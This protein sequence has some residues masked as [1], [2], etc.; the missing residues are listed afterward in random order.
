MVSSGAFAVEIVYAGAG[1]EGCCRQDRR[2][3]ASSAVAAQ[4]AT[5]LYGGLNFPF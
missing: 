5:L 4:K 3:R 2:Y 1:S